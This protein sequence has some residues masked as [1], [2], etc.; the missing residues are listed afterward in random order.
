[1][2]NFYLSFDQAPKALGGHPRFGLDESTFLAPQ[3]KRAQG[4]SIPA[5]GAVTDFKTGA[6]GLGASEFGSIIR[7][8][9]LAK[10]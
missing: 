3:K 6:L 1:V 8:E 10:A 9:R 4:E 2:R 5:Y 7:N